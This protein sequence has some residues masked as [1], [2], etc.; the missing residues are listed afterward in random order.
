MRSLEGA[1]TILP[2]AS[3]L[4]SCGQAYDPDC[5]LHPS[6]SPGFFTLA[7]VFPGQQQPVLAA[8]GTPCVTFLLRF[9]SLHYEHRQAESTQVRRGDNP[10][11]LED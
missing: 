4:Y 1:R 7:A 9:L 11:H 8:S 6:P 10:S 2:A 3:G 5:G